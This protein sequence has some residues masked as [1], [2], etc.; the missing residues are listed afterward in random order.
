MPFPRIRFFKVKKKPNAPFILGRRKYILNFRGKI[1]RRG[2][3]TEDYYFFWQMAFNVTSMII[4]LIEV[5]FMYKG[6]N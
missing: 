5:I 1:R 2:K 6:K 3:K 4:I